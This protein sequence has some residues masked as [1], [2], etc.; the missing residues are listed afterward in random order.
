M[1]DLSILMLF[2]SLQSTMGSASSAQKYSASTARKYDS[3]S[4]WSML[5]RSE[6]SCFVEFKAKTLPELCHELI[7]NW[8]STTEDITVYDGLQHVSFLADLCTPEVLESEDMRSFPA[9]DGVEPDLKDKIVNRVKETCT[10]YNLGKCQEFINTL[11]S[12]PE[13]DDDGDCVLFIPP[14][15]KDKIIGFVCRHFD[16]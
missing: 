5:V 16:Q 3:L 11:Q 4:T 2:P 12:Y 9:C 6:N 13:M 1:K 8:G 7:D 14:H 10:A 15:S